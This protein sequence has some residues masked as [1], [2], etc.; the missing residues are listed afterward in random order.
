MVKKPAIAISH[1]GCEKNRIDSEHI[2]GLLAAEGYSVS[3]N[4]TLADYVVVNSCSFIQQARE[5]PDRT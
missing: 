3:S 4:E 2:L 1:L 5:E